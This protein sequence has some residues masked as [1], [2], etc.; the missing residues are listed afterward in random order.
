MIVIIIVVVLQKR[1]LR[2]L[3]TGRAEVESSRLGA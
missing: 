3:G 2:T 1:V